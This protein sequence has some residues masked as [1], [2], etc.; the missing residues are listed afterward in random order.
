VASSIFFNISAKNKV[1]SALS[2]GWAFLITA[3]ATRTLFPIF[4]KF[5]VMPVLQ[6]LFIAILED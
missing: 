6:L 3:N 1:S 4:G 5:T 2:K